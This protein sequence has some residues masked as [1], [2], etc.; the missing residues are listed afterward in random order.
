MTTSAGGAAIEV[1][2]LTKRYADGTEAVRGVTFRVD[3]GEIVGLV[4]PNGAGK[5]TVLNMLAT[6]ITPTAGRA[7]VGGIPVSDRE[8]VRRTLGVALQ[9]TGVDPLM[10]V[11]AH[12][13]V[14]AAL[15]R[16]PGGTA[17]RRTAELLEVFQLD[18][19]ADRRAGQLSGGT[20][21]RLSLALALVHRP[22]VV[23]LDEPTVG[24]D[25]NARRAVWELLE[26]LRGNG[27]GILFST[28]YMDEAERLCQRVELMSGGRIVASGTPAGFG[29]QLSPP[30]LQIRVLG[31][32]GSAKRALGLAAAKGLLDPDDGWAIQDDV[33]RVECGLDDA[34]LC[35][36]VS[37]LRR[38]ELEILSLGWG[39]GSLDEVFAGLVRS[40]SVD[41]S[42]SSSAVEHRVLARRGGR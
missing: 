19:L 42:G 32:T 26:Q 38:H 36:L 22:R 15:Y 5:S 16:L 13:D 39:H 17:R 1:D 18:A 9:N 4:G 41:D 35:G 21:R 31:N 7:Y 24:V 33:I 37:M 8:A 6:L 34:C 28:H 3:P 40:D 20:Q 30:A 2:E 27:L 23:I 11:T 25:P 14:Q 12:F 29:R 10:T